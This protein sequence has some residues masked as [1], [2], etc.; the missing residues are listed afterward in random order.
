MSSF[1]QQPYRYSQNTTPESQDYSI[2]GQTSVDPSNT[3]QP[4]STNNGSRNIYG[5][6]VDVYKLKPSQQQQHVIMLLH[7]YQELCN[8]S[9]PS[10]CLYL[11]LLF[12]TLNNCLNQTYHHWVVD[13]LVKT[14]LMWIFNN[15]PHRKYKIQRQ[16]WLIMKVWIIHHHMVPR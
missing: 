11:H 14:K 12:P 9:K 4:P 3:M 7:H 15:K 2:P 5:C 10:Q 16:W 6:R 8:T 13:H 1:R